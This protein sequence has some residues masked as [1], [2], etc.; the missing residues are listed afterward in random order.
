MKIQFLLFILYIL[1]SKVWSQ[2]NRIDGAHIKAKD[3][4]SAFQ[5]P[6]NK[7]DSFESMLKTSSDSLKRVYQDKLSKV[8]S[9]SASFHHKTDSIQ[10]SVQHQLSSVT[11]I[12][13][14][15]STKVD[16]LKALKLPTE[17]YT[18]KLDSINQFRAKTITNAE[19]K[20]QSL[21]T[22]SADKLK[23]IN[24][25]PELQ[26]K[27]S[28]ATKNIDSFKLPTENLK[29]P[30][31]NLSQN[32]NIP[33]TSLG[34][35]GNLNVESLGKTAGLGKLPEAGGELKD[36]TGEA[37]NISS[38]TGEVGSYEKNLQN[39]VSKD[40]TDVRQLPKTMENKAGDLSGIKGIE[41]EAKVLDQYKGELDK[42]KSQDALKK[43][44]V[45]QVQKAAI[46]HFAGREQVL[47]NAMDKMGKYKEKYSSL[48]SLNEAGKKRP[49]EMRGKPLKERLLPGI[50]LQIFRK[51]DILFDFSPY[52][53]YRI[54]GKWNSGLGW[55]QRLAYDDHK[56]SLHAGGG[57]FGPRLFSEVDLYKGFF[58]RIELEVMNAYVP[59]L[60]SQTQMD[61]GH[62]QWIWSA[63][64]GL[65]KNYK[66]L[67]HVNGYTAIMVNLYNPLHK[68]PYGDVVSMRIGFEFPMK[69]NVKKNQ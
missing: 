6:L 62:R 5:K 68:S 1:P 14:K 43:E 35:V 51:N 16:S 41:G 9:I 67:K 40:A 66:F 29:M 56:H 58:P 25:P 61:A 57:V 20:I 3:Y 11:G 8:D 15:F 55:N 2:S 64:A 22:E 69:K 47:Q 34:N 24:L 63:F 18:H 48:Q 27:V 44:A 31:L 54:S 13:N 4:D 17:K 38:A 39:V 52:L 37:K 23:S 49:N 30:S 32:M 19:Q 60:T 21:K 65:K 36:L 42:I 33:E 28:D 12:E 53:G 46:N 26:N 50:G 7:I 10:S 45:N 59:P